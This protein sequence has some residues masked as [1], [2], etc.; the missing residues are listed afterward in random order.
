MDGTGRFGAGEAKLVVDGA[1]KHYVTKTGVVHALEDYSMAVREG[2]FVCVL[3]PSGCGKSTLLWAMAGLHGLTSGTVRLDGEPVVRPHPQIA[4]V[5]QDANLLPWRSL[6]KNIHLPFEI[7]GL[8]PA[9]HKDRIDALLDRV[10]LTGFQ[11]KYPR[12]LSGGMQQRASIVRSLSVDPSLLLMDE[13][14]GALDA[15]TRDEMNL[16]IEE[17]WLETGK[18]IVFITHSIAEA[19]FLADRIFVMSARPGRLSR[20]FEVDIPRPRP[21]DVTTTTHFIE[22]VAE[23]KASI[24]HGKPVPAH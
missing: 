17:I 13:P 23:V 18:T 3:G 11:T 8:R 2:E 15:F 4:M 12:E 7:K 9:E 22:L 21:L 6:I 14:F 20:V 19:V 1:T 5:F 10:G 16:L 24:D